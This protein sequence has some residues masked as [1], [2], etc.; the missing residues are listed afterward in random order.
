MLFGEADGTCLADD[1][2]LD[3]TGIGHLVLN[4][5]CDFRRQFFGL[6]VVNLIGTDNDAEL[7][8][9]LDGVGLEDTGI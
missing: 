4:A 5:A 1:R 3:L 6:G 9:G 8:A 2:N 7:S